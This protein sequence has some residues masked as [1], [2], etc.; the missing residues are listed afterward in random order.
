MSRPDHPLFFAMA[1][2][3][4]RRVGVLAGFYLHKNEGGAL[5]GDYIDFAVLGTVAGGH[6][7][8]TERSDVINGQDLGSA[9]ECQKAMEKKRKRH[10]VKTSPFRSNCAVIDRAYRVSA[11][12]SEIVSMAKSA[13]SSS[14]IRGGERRMVD[15]LAP[16]ISNPRRKHS[17][18]IASRSSPEASS[19]PIIRPR[20]R[21]SMIAGCR[22]FRRSSFVRKYSPS[23]AEF[24]TYFSS[25]SRTVSNAAAKHTGFPPNVDA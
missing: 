5:P 17:L 9:A 13:C 25:R 2:G 14:I 8:V 1:D 12:A 11:I 6:D 10:S 16:R 19:M 18:R 7:P 22:C 4:L 20:P 21:T 15:R 23:F 24:A 3:V